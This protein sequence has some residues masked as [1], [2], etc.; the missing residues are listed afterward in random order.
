M[1]VTTRR[2][3]REDGSLQPTLFR[4]EA[5]TFP[6]RRTDEPRGPR[7]LSQESGRARRL[8]SLAQR[9]NMRGVHE[10][11]SAPSPGKRYAA[12]I[13][14][15][16]PAGHGIASTAT[17]TI[18]EFA[19]DAGAVLVVHHERIDVDGQLAL[20]GLI[21]SVE[22]TW[23]C[24]PGLSLEGKGPEARGGLAETLRTAA[25]SGSVRVYQPDG[26]QEWRDFDAQVVG[27]RVRLG[28]GGFNLDNGPRDDAYVVGLGLL[29]RAAERIAP[30]MRRAA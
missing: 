22:R 13:V 24:D 9:S 26:S 4:P 6:A 28:T 19:A 14:V 15:S 2:H 10:R 25:A 11:Q 16:C 27:A 20:A 5:L 12:S 3:K 8:F 29:L 21:A 30:P 18:G 23:G 17:V 1:A 7:P